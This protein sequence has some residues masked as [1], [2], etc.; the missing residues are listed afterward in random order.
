M[1]DNKELFWNASLEELKRGYVFDIST[2]K[3]ICILCGEEFQKGY[4]YPLENNFLDAEKAV[5]KHIERE[6]SSMFEFLLGMNKK[7]SGLTEHQKNLLNYFYKGYSDKEVVAELGGGNTS[8]IRNHRFTLREK[9]KQARIFLAIMELLKEKTGEKNRF[10][11]IHG[12]VPASDERYAI[13]GQEN[14]K[15]LTTYFREGLEGPLSSFPVKEKKKVAILNHLIK[16]FDTGRRYSE[17]EVNEILKKVYDDY[18][19]LRRYLIEYEFLDR[20]KDGSY[21]WVK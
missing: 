12:P 7:Y 19:S 16:K 20:E 4:I 6:H 18:V 8:T 3:Y 11:N 5:E 9:E 21:Y 14:E 10:I 15:I 1:M 17:K 2:E 13:T